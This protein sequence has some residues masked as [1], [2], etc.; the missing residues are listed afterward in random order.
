MSKKQAPN[1]ADQPGSADPAEELLARSVGMLRPLVDL[2]I[3]QGVGYPSLSRALRTAFVDSARE[4]LAQ[5]SGS[6]A[7][8]DAAVSLRSGV[9]RKEVRALNEARQGAADNPAQN[10]KQAEQQERS[11][12][13]AEQVYTRW[14]TDATYHNSQSEPATLPVSGDA[15]SFE[16]LVTSVT[17]DFSRRTVL[18]ELV[19]LG[20]VAVQDNRVAPLAMAMVPQAWDELTQYFA[21]HLHDHMAAGAANL[22]AAR[23][24]DKTPFLEHSMYANGL[25]DLSIE[26]L[27]TLAR[28]VWKPAFNQMV[29]AA[30][31]RYD[32][33][34]QENRQGR[35]RFG[36]YLYSEP[37]QPDPT[38]QADQGQD[39]EASRRAK[40]TK[41]AGAPGRKAA[42]TTN[43]SKNRTRA[44]KKASSKRQ[45]PS[46]R[47][48]R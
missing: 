5:E 45:S 4:Q 29:G 1:P 17:R 35:L 6:D 7:V 38:L 24:G 46:K 15:P 47:S 25:S 20:M 34:S 8:T 32:L 28:D 41:K 16:S 12:S 26:Q 39:Q 31:Q 36:V 21:D 3:S 9:H 19:R 2:L 30:R 40:A 27:S 13:V 33:D 44:G 43:N 37:D 22:K 18:D 42:T 14:V 23:G 10:G 11:L 48:H